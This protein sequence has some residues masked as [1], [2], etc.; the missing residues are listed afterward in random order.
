MK[1]LFA[2]LSITFLFLSHAVAQDIPARPEPPRLVND[3]AGFLNS[4]EIEQLEQRLVAFDDSTSTQIVVVIVQDLKGNDPNMY[5][6]KIG[7][8]WGVGQ[9]GKNNGI[10]LLI[11]PKTAESNGQAAIAVGYG[12]E[13]V[14][15]DI[16]AGSIIDNE[17]I[18]RFKEQKFYEGIDAAVSA[19]MKASAGEYKAVPKK[20]K[21]GGS[22]FGL[23]V[24]L[25]F[26]LIIILSIKKGNSNHHTMGRGGSSIPFWLL[27]GGMMGSSNKSGGSWGNFSSGSGSFGGFGGGGFGGGGASGSW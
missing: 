6:F 11:K 24:F 2:L 9:K 7:Q 14:I 3:Y 20:K 12:L 19:I 22:K 25:V 23:I 8:D 16:T 27:M 15:P 4:A 10:V 26:I 21:Q 18:P 1:Q 13:A 17:L 5:A